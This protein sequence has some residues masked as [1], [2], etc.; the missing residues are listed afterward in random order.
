MQL[1]K[2]YSV[3]AVEYVTVEF[4]DKYWQDFKEEIRDEIRSEMD[5][6][7]IRYEWDGE[8]VDWIVDKI[9]NGDPEVSLTEHIEPITRDEM[10]VEWIN[11]NV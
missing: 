6:E 8:F 11:G 2:T 10:E 5:D 3:S 4:P 1:V 7:D 9:S